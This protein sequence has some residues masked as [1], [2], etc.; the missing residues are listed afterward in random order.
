LPEL[1]ELP[2]RA[3]SGNPTYFPLTSKSL[4][5]FDG[6]VVFDAVADRRGGPYSKPS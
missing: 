4:T 3:R 2:S 6:L 5:Q 1:A